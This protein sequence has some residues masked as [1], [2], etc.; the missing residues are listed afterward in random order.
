MKHLVLALCLMATP[1]TA[2][3]PLWV[4]E[5]PNTDFS[6]SSVT[7][8]EI[9]SGG[10]GR[11]GIPALDNPAYEP[12]AN[13]ELTAQEPVMV[14]EINGQARAYPIRYLM[15]HEIANTEVGGVP[16]AVTYCPLCNSGLV[17]DR[18]L[19]GQTL[20]FGVTGK[21]RFSDMVMYDR[22]SESWWQQFTGEGIVGEM[23]GAQLEVMVSW[24]SP[25]EGF[26]AE[27]PMG[28]VM[29]RPQ[30][31][32]SYGTNPY[33]GYDSSSRPFLY[34]GEMPPHDIP[35]L[36][37]VVRVGDRAWTLDRLQRNPELVED[38]IRF[39]WASGMNSPLDT[40]QISAGR[41]IGSIRVFDAETGAPVV[42]EVVFAFAF[43]AFVPDGRWMLGN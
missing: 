18:R 41:D 25:W 4:H 28:E 19:G 24:M 11:D 6:S 20:S 17:F 37:R 10:P 13:A 22:Q 16:V 12:A 33:G 8:T 23:R 32:R 29:S 1:L 43:H 35:P 7:F 14:V 42:H 34:S 30:S 26:V 15:W 9:L 36:A 40:S 39:T 21:L 3:A 5:W 31:P 2:Q 38:G 27:F